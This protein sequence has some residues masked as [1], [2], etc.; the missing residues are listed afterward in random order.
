MPTDRRARYG[1]SPVSCPG[2]LAVVDMPRPTLQLELVAAETAEGVDGI[3]M[4]SLF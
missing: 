2:S 3:D 1:D 4:L